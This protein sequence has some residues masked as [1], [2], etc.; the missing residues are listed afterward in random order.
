MAAAADAASVVAPGSQERN[1]AAAAIAA[2]VGARVAGS[3][4]PLHPLKP[5]PIATPHIAAAAAFARD[6]SPGPRFA[7]SSNIARMA[8]GEGS[9]MAMGVA[10]RRMAGQMAASPPVEAGVAKVPAEASSSSGSLL[11]SAEAA[12]PIVLGDDEELDEIEFGVW[13]P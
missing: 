13:A 7:G 12:A 8:P 6:V 5:I 10:T 4:A 3:K 2:G 1:S 11:S 9:D